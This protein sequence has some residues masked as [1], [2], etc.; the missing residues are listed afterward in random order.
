[1]ANKD[2]QRNVNTGKFN[3][4]IKSADKIEISR[5]VV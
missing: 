5:V 1:M 4:K 3:F 2:E